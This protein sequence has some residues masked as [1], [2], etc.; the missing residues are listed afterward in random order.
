MPLLFTRIVPNCEFCAVFTVALDAPADVVDPPP[1][2]EPAPDVVVAAELLGV[3]LHAAARMATPATT[4]MVVATRVRAD[5]GERRAGHPDAGTSRSWVVASVVVVMGYPS[6]DGSTVPCP[7][8]FT[9]L[10]PPR[11]CVA[12]V[13]TKDTD[14]LVRMFR[15]RTSPKGSCLS[16]PWRL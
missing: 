5:R 9:Q 10:G 6:L 13:V 12:G 4:P 8:G 16:L 1:L 15:R 7:S 14:R 2:F 11:N 3:E